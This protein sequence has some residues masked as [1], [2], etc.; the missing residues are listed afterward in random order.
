MKDYTAG[1]KPVFSDKVKIVEITD[2]VHADN[3]NA[4]AKQLI[5]NDLALRKMLE[6]K[7]EAEEGMG[8][9]HN[10]F[11]DTEKEKLAGIAERANNYAHPATHPASMIEQDSTH[12]FVS[13]TKQKEWDAIYAQAVAYADLLIANLINGA[14]QALDTLGEIAN[15]MKENA[16]VVTALHEAIGKKANEAEL[17]QVAFSGSYNDL[18]DRPT[19]LDGQDGTS[20]GFGIPTAS[21]DANTGTPS[22]TVTASGPDTAKVFHFEFRNLKGQTGNT[23]QA[24]KDGDK[25]DKGDRGEPGA[26]GTR[27]SQWYRGTGITG[28]STTATAFSSSGV[29][30]AL[31][32]DM[33]L[34]T[35]TGNVYTCT[36]AGAASAAKW[37]YSGNIKG[38]TGATGAT[39]SQGQKGDKGDK[40]DTGATG[41][42]GPKGA[43][44]Q[45]NV[46]FATAKPSSLANGV[47]CMVYE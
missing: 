22:V 45:A 9:S 5:E 23:G 8:M 37:V 44:G 36:A 12:R 41:P 10:D 24:G 3:A 16:D 34:N 31:V 25:G 38:A 21:I 14:P 28:T 11:T 27:G 17:S 29:S 4:A 46:T 39:G 43:D 26:A 40:G 20:A 13:D 6:S 35:S 18:A 32:N 33:Y 2:P 30:S 7:A 42:Q 19:A 47:I 1:N 15:A